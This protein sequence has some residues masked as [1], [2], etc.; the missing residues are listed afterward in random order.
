[1]C[2]T[3][4]QTERPSFPQELQN[5]MREEAIHNNGCIRKNNNKTKDRLT[6]LSMLL[7]H[8]TGF[9]VEDIRKGKL[10]TCEGDLFSLFHI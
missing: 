8:Y 4:T 2:A 10:K 7:S 3:K 9:H 5:L 1:M 6:A